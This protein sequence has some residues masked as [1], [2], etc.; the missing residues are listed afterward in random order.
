MALINCPECGK[1]ISEISRVC[2][3]CGYPLEDN[4]KNAQDSN[5]IDVTPESIAVNSGNKLADKSVSQNL[6]AIIIVAV[7]AVV[8]AVVGVIAFIIDQNTLNSDE[9]RIYDLMYDYRLY[10]KDPDSMQIRDNAVYMIDDEGNNYAFFTI[11]ANNSYGGKVTSVVIYMNH[12]FMGNYEDVRDSGRDMELTREERI[13][14]LRSEGA[15]LSWTL[16]GEK[17][18]E[19]GY[20]YAVSVDCKK[21]ANKLGCSYIET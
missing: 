18:T 16:H 21:I 11:S 9:Q 4:E 8:I 14:Y 6:K 1:E 7:V 15:F 5:T 12:S 10:L 3:N 2:I 19:H 17:A 13:E 20:T